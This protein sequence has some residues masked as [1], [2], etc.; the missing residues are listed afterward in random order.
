MTTQPEYILE[1]NLVQQLTDI[2]YA[3]VVIKDEADLIANLRVQ[4]EKHNKCTLSD[5]E[6]KQ[7]LHVL[8]KGNIYEKAKTL[9]EKLSYTKDDGSTGYLE[10]LV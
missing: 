5:T 9:R 2:G 8:S 10:L 6:F 3:K 1:E 7:V 4:L